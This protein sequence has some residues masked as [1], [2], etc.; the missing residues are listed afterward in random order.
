MHVSSRIKI[1]Q[2]NA[3]HCKEH[4]ILKNKD[5]LSQKSAAFVEYKMQLRQI[6]KN[7]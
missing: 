4:T 5:L 7:V 6:L 3:S 1:Q 2:L